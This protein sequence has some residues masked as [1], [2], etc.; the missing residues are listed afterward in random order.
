M[1][2]QSS[3]S[4]IYLLLAA[5]ML[6]LAIAVTVVGIEMWRD[7][8][9]KVIKDKANGHEPVL[10][11]SPRCKWHLF[12][13]HIWSSGQ[14]QVATIKRQLQ[15]M[16]P[17]I[18]IFLDVDD[19]EDIGALET[20]VNQTTVL[21]FLCAELDSNSRGQNPSCKLEPYPGASQ[22]RVLL[23]ERVPIPLVTA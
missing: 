13:S 17:G 4:F 2:L 3:D 21:L 12:L 15:L 16:M 18:S 1:S 8:Q 9:A 14:D 6:L 11:Q 23:A 19:L 7:S 20:Y 10:T 5:C 22:L